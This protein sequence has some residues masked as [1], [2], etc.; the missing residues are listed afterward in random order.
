MGVRAS[1]LFPSRT[2]TFDYFGSEVEVTYNQQDNTVKF[3]RELTELEFDEQYATL[4]AKVVQEW[5]LEDDDGNEI[6][7]E[8]E[9]MIEL[10]IHF[11]RELLNAI[12]EDAVGKD[13]SPNGSSR[14]ERRAAARNGTSG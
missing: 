12:G 1:R 6:G 8:V 13:G 10:P 2:F 9:D 14:R 11:L 3:N 5:N 4:A 7:T